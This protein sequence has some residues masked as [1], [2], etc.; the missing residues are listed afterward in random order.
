MT[1]FPQLCSAR[2]LVRCIRQQSDISRA[3]DRLGQHTLVDS[4]IARNATGQNLA[5]L[6]N[7]VPEKPGVF[8]VNDIYLLD[9]K[10]ADSSPAKAAPGTTAPA[11]GRTTSIEI[12][13]SA[14]VTPASV[15]V[16][17]V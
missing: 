3:L 17:I 14:V 16:F 15:S 10:P 6:R 5:A 8:E 11:L 7:K 2:Y 4:T 1:P 13:V 9:A 12:V